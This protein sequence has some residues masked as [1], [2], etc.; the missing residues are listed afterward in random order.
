MNMKNITAG[1]MLGTL[2]VMSTHLVA[3]NCDL[4]SLLKK[5]DAYASNRDIKALGI[6]DLIADQTENLSAQAAAKLG[7]AWMYEEG[8][9]VGLKTWYHDK[10]L[11]LLIEVSN[12]ERNKVAQA[13]AWLRLGI[14]YRQGLPEHIQDKDKAQEFIKKAAEQNVDPNV[15]KSA[16]DQMRFFD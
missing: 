8:P 9:E 13:K 15:Q 3:I 10:A 7:M 4:D 6:Y 14:M 12:Q 11:E 2:T 16:K 1:L 5:A